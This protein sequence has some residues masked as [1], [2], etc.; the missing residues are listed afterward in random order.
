MKNVFIAAAALV[1]FSFLSPTATS[2]YICDSPNAKK[3]HFKKDC[4]GLKR[5]TH[6]IKS[7]TKDEAVKRGYSVCKAE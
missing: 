1:C 5:C 3:Y 4:S 2:V 6:T 7:L